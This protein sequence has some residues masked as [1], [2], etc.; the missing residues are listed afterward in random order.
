M[1]IMKNTVTR[2]VNTL[3]AAAS[4]LFNMVL[5]IS[6][7]ILFI[8]ILPLIAP[9]KFTT[10]TSVASTPLYFSIAALRTNF[11]LSLLLR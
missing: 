7:M 6:I 5:I 2:N 3:S 4:L 1:Q 9:Y 8:L 11:A 10:R